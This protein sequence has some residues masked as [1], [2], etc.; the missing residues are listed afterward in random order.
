M[1]KA[2]ILPCKSWKK[3]GTSLDHGLKEQALDNGVNIP[4]GETTPIG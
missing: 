1:S 2:G 3:G 4:F